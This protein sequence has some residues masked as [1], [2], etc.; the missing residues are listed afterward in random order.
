MEKLIDELLVEVEKTRAELKE[1]N[2][3]EVSNVRT[4][5]LR[6][7]STSINTIRKG[8][9]EPAEGAAPELMTN[10]LA[11]KSSS[12]EWKVNLNI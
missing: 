3:T 6:R 10:R 1:L 11:C 2:G 9:Q 5:K 8:C 7:A 4:P 12:I